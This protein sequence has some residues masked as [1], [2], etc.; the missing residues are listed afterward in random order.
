MEHFERKFSLS[1]L[2]DVGKIQAEL[3][4]GVLQ[5]ILPKRSGEE[6]KTGGRK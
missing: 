1:E 6:S 5:V 2:I 3:E 4:R